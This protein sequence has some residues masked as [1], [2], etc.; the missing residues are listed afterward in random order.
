[1]AKRRGLG[2]QIAGSRVNVNTIFSNFMSTQYFS[3]SVRYHNL[4]D[5]IVYRYSCSFARGV[6]YSVCIRFG[7]YISVCA[8]VA[9]T[10][11]TQWHHI[12][13]IRYFTTCTLAF[14]FTC[15]EQC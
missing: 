4:S 10:G 3:P 11:S 12:T 6:E 15:E 7:A 2:L 14:V 1:M 8:C 5:L 13:R 9:A